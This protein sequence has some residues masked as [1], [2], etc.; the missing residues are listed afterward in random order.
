MAWAKKTHPVFVV[1]AEGMID[2]DEADN[3]A[4]DNGSE[5]STTTGTADSYGQDPMPSE[6]GP[7]SPELENISV[8]SPTQSPSASDTDDT[9]PPLD[10]FMLW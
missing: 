7:A 8:E 2:N 10:L 6:R 4:S 5:E 9:A 1:G 3:Q